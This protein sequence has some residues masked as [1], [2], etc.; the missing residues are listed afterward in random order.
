MKQASQ[1]ICLKRLTKRIFEKI[2]QNFEFLELFLTSYWVQDENM[3][4][5]AICIQ[6][7]GAQKL[8][9]DDPC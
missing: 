2:W 1:L 8:G 9:G 4:D 3:V 7:D 6:L 5:L